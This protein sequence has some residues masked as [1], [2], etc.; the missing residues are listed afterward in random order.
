AVS[1][2]AGDDVDA[3]AGLDAGGA[4]V[5][6]LEVDDL[7]FAYP[8][9]TPSLHGVSLRVEQR[10]TVA[11]IGPNGAGKSTLLL[12]LN[13]ILRAASGELRVLGERLDDRSVGRI[14]AQ[15]GL[16]FSNPDDQ[17]FS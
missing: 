4:L 10:E 8:D 15:V 2:H 12:H 7:H 11:L 9:G 17:L 1:I 16:L 14:R 3:R 5:P 13:G 6:A